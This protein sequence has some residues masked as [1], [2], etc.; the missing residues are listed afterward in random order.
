MLS[1][2]YYF[3]T[4]VYFFGFCCLCNMSTISAWAAISARS[5]VC[6]YEYV[7]V[8]YVHAV[9]LQVVYVCKCAQ[10]RI[11]FYKYTYDMNICPYLP[12]WPPMSLKDATFKLTIVNA[13]IYTL[14]NMQIECMFYR[15]PLPYTT[16]IQIHDIYHVMVYIY[17]IRYFMK[18]VP[19]FDYVCIIVT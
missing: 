6:K 11:V 14:Y 13:F 18:I 2:Q 1:F 12:F 17:R 8:E 16:N 9:C 5:T 3:L 4:F 19:K 7:V 10:Q 15:M